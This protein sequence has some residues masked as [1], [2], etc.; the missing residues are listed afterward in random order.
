MLFEYLENNT[1][2]R[3]GLWISVS[4]VFALPLLAAV[5]HGT[6]AG[7]LTLGSATTHLTH[8]YALARPDTFDKTKENVVV[9]LSDAAIPDDALWEDFPGLKLAAAG[10]LHAIQVEINADR[11]VK[12]AAIFHDAFVDSQ[13][14]QGIASPVFEA[15]TFDGT[16]VEGKLASGAPEEL[17]SKSFE[18]TATFRAPVLHRPAPTATGAAAAQT[19]PARIVLAFL[20]A[21]GAGD[22]GAIR[23]LLSA[24]YG[25]P[26]DGP[27]AKDILAA[28]KMSLP[29]PTTTE[30][31]TVDVRGT[32]AEVVMVNTS[33]P[34]DLAAKFTLV[35]ESGAWRIDSAMM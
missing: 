16:T 17:V 26:L 28:W 10:K 24:E 21:A 18:F 33:R 32:S 30:I 22:K 3:I 20:Q 15:A 35:L 19:P 27:R 6:A 23:K 5:E 11:S 29:D 7:T 9:V 14:F 8:A 34:G 2:K 13:S 12:S 1:M 4:L 31:S 25:K